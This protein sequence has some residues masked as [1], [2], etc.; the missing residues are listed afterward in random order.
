MMTN[1][2]DYCKNNQFYKPEPEPEPVCEKCE[3]SFC[4]K[5]KLIDRKYCDFHACSTFYCGNVAIHNG[6]NGRIC[7]IHKYKEESSS[8]NCSIM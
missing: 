6:L 4:F 2:S 5:A 7:D 3:I 8:A 1:N